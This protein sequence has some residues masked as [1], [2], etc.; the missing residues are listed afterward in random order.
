MSQKPPDTSVVQ[1]VVSGRH[2]PTIKN[3]YVELLGCGHTYVHVIDKVLPRGMYRECSR[4]ACAS[5]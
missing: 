1:K 4:C 3:R 5:K 2:H